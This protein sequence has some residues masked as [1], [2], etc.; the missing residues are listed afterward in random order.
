M[1]ILITALLVL[2]AT[3]MLVVEVA[4]IPGFGFTGTL[5]VLSMVGSVFYAFTQLGTA[6]GWITMLLCVLICVALFLWALYGNTID[7]MALKKN[8]DSTVNDQDMSLFSVGDRGVTRTRLALIGEALING[9][10]VEVTK[11]RV[12][13]CPLFKK[14]R[15]IEELNEETIREN[16]EFRMGAFGM[17]CDNRDVRM[18][19]FLSFGISELMSLALAKGMMDAVVM[20]ADGCGTCILTDPGIIQGLGGRISAIIETSPIDVVLD[21]VGRDN[22]LDPETVPVDMRAGVEKAFSKGYGRL[23]VTVASADDA[24]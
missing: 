4:F 1:D 12:K 3:A 8:I 7:R 13:Y 15:G 9:K 23:A 11:P 20:A 24:E 21:A 17:C 22:V 19:Y 2:F 16:M 6:A 5:G 18:D 10:V 14:H